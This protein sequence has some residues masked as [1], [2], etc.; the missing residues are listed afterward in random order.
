MRAAF[1][2]SVVALVLAISSSMSAFAAE[3]PPGLEPLP[4]VLP[5]PGVS[6]DGSSVLEP[7]VTIVKKGQETI[8]EYRINGELYMMK[9]T[10]ANGGT[11]YYLHK[12]DQNGGWVNDGPSPPLSVP[13]WV[14][15]KF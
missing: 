3:P 10:P 6:E 1:K 12:D 13:K 14:I 11:P 4:E 8:E 5:P 2:L 9:V 15:F 7:E